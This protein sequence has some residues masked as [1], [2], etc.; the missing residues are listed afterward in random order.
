MGFIPVLGANKLR[1]N[2]ARQYPLSIRLG[3]F[4]AFSLRVLA[5]D[6]YM[7]FLLLSK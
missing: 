7:F 3:V 2:V 5:F 1:V 4:A 6:G